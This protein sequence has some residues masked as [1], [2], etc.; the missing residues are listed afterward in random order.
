MYLLGASRARLLWCSLALVVARSLWCLFALVLACSG[1]RPPWCSLALAVARSGA[2]PLW[3]LVALDTW[4]LWRLATLAHD[5]LA[6]F[7]TLLGGYGGQF[8]RYSFSSNHLVLATLPHYCVSISS[9]PGHLLSATSRGVWC[10]Y[11]RCLSTPSVEWKLKNQI[12]NIFL[13]TIVVAV[14]NLHDADIVDAVSPMAML[15]SLSQM[16]ATPMLPGGNTVAATMP[17]CPCCL[18]AMLSQRQ[19]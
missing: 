7:S 2:R 15:N 13:P 3:F 12:Q 17:A 14:C 8:S 4:Q 11:P 5:L 9:G 6:Y 1:A 19:C 18:E 16:P 10:S